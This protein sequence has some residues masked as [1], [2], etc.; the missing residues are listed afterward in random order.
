MLYAKKPEKK[1]KEESAETKGI[2]SQVPLIGN[3]QSDA[4]VL[5]FHK[6]YGVENLTF[7][8]SLYEL[9]NE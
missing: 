4:T 9:D 7:T 3:F 1:K 8:H 6:F 5:G 2:L